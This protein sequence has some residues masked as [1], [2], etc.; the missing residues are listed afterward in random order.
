M[1]KLFVI[2]FKEVSGFKIYFNE[3]IRYRDTLILKNDGR[4][5]DSIDLNFVKLVHQSTSK[6]DNKIYV[7]FY[8]E[9]I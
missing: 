1:K 6:L 7:R 3:V 9:D 2:K 5:V 4:Y 8:L